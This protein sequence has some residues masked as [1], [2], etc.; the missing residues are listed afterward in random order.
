[1]AS[2]GMPQREGEGHTASSNTGW[3]RRGGL[4]AVAAVAVAVAVAVV[5][6]R[7]VRSVA[8]SP[9]RYKARTLGQRRLTSPR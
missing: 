4:T 1:M 6:A 9:S 7:V 2:Q 5:R 3:R 8:A